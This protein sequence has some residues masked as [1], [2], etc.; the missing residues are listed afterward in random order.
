[1]FLAVFMSKV[2]V[3]ALSVLS[4]CLRYAL[5]LIKR[6]EN[7]NRTLGPLSI[8]IVRAEVAEEQAAAIETGNI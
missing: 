8:E 4:F 6:I 1:M 5:T 7:S 3:I 2:Y